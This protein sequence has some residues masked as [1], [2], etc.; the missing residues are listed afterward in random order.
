MRLKALN[1][2]C[3][4]LKN[5]RDDQ[6]SRNSYAKRYTEIKTKGKKG[7]SKLIMWNMV[8][9]DGYFEGAKK[10]DLDFHNI[11]WGD[12]LD[13][14]SIEQLKQC[15]ALVFGRV[16][17]EGM[18]AYWTTAQSEPGEVADFMNKIPKIVFSLLPFFSAPL[19]ESFRYPFQN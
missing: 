19:R 5:K 8:T 9:L 14:F 11:V 1:N 13:Q 2:S 6:A 3:S 4:D 7:V 16:T 10:W 17:Y 12:E 18:A 15:N